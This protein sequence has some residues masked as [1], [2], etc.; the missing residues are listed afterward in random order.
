MSTRE[1]VDAILSSKSSDAQD[2]IVQELNDRK[3]A[4]TSEYKKAAMADYFGGVVVEGEEEEEDG[5]DV[6]KE[7]D[8][9]KEG[10]GDPKDKEKKKDKE[11]DSDEDDS[12]DDD[13]DED[14]DKD[15]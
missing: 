4:F 10:K 13:D 6:E 5:E 1:I 15:D 3:T 2:L 9:Q 7:S 14:E 11:D 12:S 8:K